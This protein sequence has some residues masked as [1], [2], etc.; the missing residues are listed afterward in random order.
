MP[1]TAMIKVEPSACPQLTSQSVGC[2][3]RP[4]AHQN[5]DLALLIFLLKPSFLL[6]CYII[7]IQSK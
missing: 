5:E 3:I 1:I 2:M 6:I 4:S 7:D